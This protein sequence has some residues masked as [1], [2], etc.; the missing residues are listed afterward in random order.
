MSQ[1]FNTNDLSASLEALLAAAVD[2]KVA[3]G[4]S[5]VAF[6]RQG[7]F[8]QAATGI[9]DVETKKPVT[10]DT[11]V[12]L[13]ST[14]KLAVSL[15]T[16][17]AAEK[18]DFDIDSHEQLVRLV[19][20]LG[21]DWEGTNVYD[22]FDG[23]DEKGDW[24]FKKSPE[25]K[26]TTR[27][28]LAHTAGFG[29]FFSREECAWLMETAEGKEKDMSSLASI[30]TPRVYEAGKTWQYGNSPEWLS[31]LLFRLTSLPLRAAFQQYLF[32]P[33]GIAPD[34]LDSF[35][36]PPMDAQRGSIA[37]QV[38][39]AQEFIPLPFP[40]DTP[41]YEAEQPEGLFPLASAPLW[42][43]L[44]AYVT[45]LQSIL[46]DEGPV[47]RNGS[48]L[49]S[50]SMWEEARKDALELIGTEIP[51]LPF[52]QS[53]APVFAT[54][55]EWLKKPKV[56]REGSKHPFGWSLLQAAVLKEESETGLQPGTLT[57]CGMADIYY[58]IDRSQ[59]IGAIVTTQVLPWGVEEI[60][61]LRDEVE[62]WVVAK[63]PKRAA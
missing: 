54:A 61:D 17:R 45:I 28:L 59:G 35:R 20:E 3:P 40:F 13:A 21:R 50:Q 6:D 34:T 48:P 7:V 46:N 62:R 30:N 33:L 53:T 1:M 38:P 57:W 12:W 18:H 24:K 5:A 31:V 26:I 14:S 63:N 43:T 4:L 25:D 16:L 42:G 23:K 47:D 36:T 32:D 41:Q 39:R 19:P 29:A 44:P 60:L 37:M 49:L 52:S 8:A 58:F 51:Q 9:A 10:L 27:Q 55:I 15:L 11:V 22:L 56:A 2:R